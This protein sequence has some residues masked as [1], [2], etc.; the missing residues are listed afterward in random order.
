MRFVPVQL[1]P[2][3]R[4]SHSDEERT[5][6]NTLRVGNLRVLATGDDEH[7]GGQARRVEELFRAVEKVGGA[8]WSMK[9]GFR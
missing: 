1:Q 5:Q 3:V 7:L 8:V 9:K 2:D 4:N 6:E